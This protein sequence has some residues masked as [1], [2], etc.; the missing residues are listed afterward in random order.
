[1]PR[2][3]SERYREMAEEFTRRVIADLDG[4]VDSIVLYGSVA[5]GQARRDSDIDVLVI[6]PDVENIRKKVSSIRNDFT[7]ETEYMVY[8]SLVF[9]SREDFYTLQQVGSPFI[10]DV[11]RDGVVLY[12]R[13]TY[14]GLRGETA[15]AG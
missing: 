8:L 15:A 6:S 7:Y 12:D 14:L 3:I 5:R 4:A 13:G 10:Q 2:K 9:L 11:V 1:M